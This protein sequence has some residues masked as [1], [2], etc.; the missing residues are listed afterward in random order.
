MSIPN[1]IPRLQTALV[2]T[3]D[4]GIAISRQTKVPTL[5][6]GMVLVRT[7]AISVNPVDTKMVG[8]YVTSGAISGCDFA[9]IVVAIG[10]Q[11]GNK[12]VNCGDRVFGAVMGMNPLEPEL[13]AFTTYVGAP[14]VGLIK[15]PPSM[16]FESGSALGRSFMTAGL[17]LFKS[18]GLLGHPLRPTPNPKPVLVYGGSTATGTAA[19]QLL[20]LAGFQ[21]IVTCSPHN[22]PLVKSFG[23]D[24]LFD[25]H[26]PNCAADIRSLTKNNLV[27]ALDCIMTADSMKVCY[28]AIGRAGGRYTS[29]DPFLESIAQTRK[30]IKADWVLGPASKSS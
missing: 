29:L 9:G 11:T 24:V 14:S 1:E 17:A 2:G 8:P 25:Y 7:M 26:S 28:G 12:K 20:K 30:V 15:L 5:N 13:G 21:T 6:A 18:L 23:G 22:F 3:A 16:S 10:D 4:G 27:Y 19:I